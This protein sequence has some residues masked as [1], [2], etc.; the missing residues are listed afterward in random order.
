MEYFT[1]EAQEITFEEKYKEDIR[2]K[3]K[4]LDEIQKKTNK[5]QKFTAYAYVDKPERVFNVENSKVYLNGIVCPTQLVQGGKRY[6]LDIHPHL[7]TFFDKY[8]SYTVAFSPTG[9]YGPTVAYCAAKDVYPAK[10]IASDGYKLLVEDE[11]KY[12]I[13]CS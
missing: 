5:L 11:S 13:I 1:S 9:K 6:R 7:N 8:K 4:E 2:T 3:Q 10:L 12:D